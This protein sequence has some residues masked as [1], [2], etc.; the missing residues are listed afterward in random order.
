VDA[1]DQ[2]LRVALAIRV[3][4]IQLVI[5]TGPDFRQQMLRAGI[6]HLDAVLLTHEHNDHII[7]IDDVRPFN[8]M[9]GK[10]MP[11]YATTRV[12]RELQQRFAYIFQTE[13]RYPGAPMLTL[14]S[15]QKEHT[16][17]VAGVDVQPIE[18]MHGRLPVLGFR[19]GRFAYITDMKTIAP[20]EFKKL[21]EVSH[22][23]VNALHHKEHHSHLNLEQALAFAKRV[24]AQHTYFTHI[25][26]RMGLH[27]EVDTDLPEGIHLA[28]DGLEVQV[29]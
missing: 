20:E 17:S 2:R 4:N 21:K 18:V 8:F 11:V 13:N 12:Q 5:D 14:H 27:A 28:Y 16:F 19:I 9:Q 6:Q 10:D 15:I 1:R 3:G 25:S 7:G 24:G 22:L 23:V 26:H 29:P